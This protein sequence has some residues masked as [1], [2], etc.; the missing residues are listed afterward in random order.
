LPLG[1]RI[2]T[3]LLGVGL[4]FCSVDS[5]DTAILLYKPLCVQVLISKGTSVC[6]DP[7]T[8]ERQGEV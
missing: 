7:I 1:F 2:P 4:G 3:D 6:L 8:S 5:G